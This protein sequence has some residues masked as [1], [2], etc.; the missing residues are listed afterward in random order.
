MADNESCALSV[1]SVPTEA[2]SAQGEQGPTASQVRAAH[3][4]TTLRET[5][6][7]GALL[8]RRPDSNRERPWRPTARAMLPTER[9]PF[10]IPYRKEVC[11]DDPK[12]K[13]ESYR[14]PK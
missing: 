1:L 11:H 4:V 9:L 8:K 5:L 2:A 7:V 12:V 10:V 14:R 13:A 6:H 3:P